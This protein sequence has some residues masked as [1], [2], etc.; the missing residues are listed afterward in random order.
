MNRD[1]FEFLYNML[2][3]SVTHKQSFFCMSNN[4]SLRPP[5][6]F[7]IFSIIQQLKRQKLKHWMMDKI[8]NLKGAECYYCC[9]NPTEMNVQ[10]IL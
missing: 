9:E 5:I 6:F 1:R 4:H 10:P 7:L 8:Q 3:Q 2:M